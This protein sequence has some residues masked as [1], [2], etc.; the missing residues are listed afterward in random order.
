MLPELPGA[1]SITLLSL[2]N[3][4]YAVAEVALNFTVSK[5]VV[6]MGCSLDGQRN[7]TVAGNTTL[8]G[9]P[10]GMHTLTVYANDTFGF[11][12][13]SEAVTFTVAESFP[14]TLVAIAVAVTVAAVVFAGLLVYFK[15]RR[16]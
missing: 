12:G 7:V 5:R 16:H 11:T 13:A 10:E 2:G 6:W 8:A 14:S 9:L 3:E 15:K 4:T 1:P